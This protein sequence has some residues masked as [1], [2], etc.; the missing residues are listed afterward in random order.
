MRV[1]LY[2]YIVQYSLILLLSH[3]ESSILLLLLSTCTCWPVLQ[4]NS[5]TLLWDTLLWKA[6]VTCTPFPFFY[7]F[8]RLVWMDAWMLFWWMNESCGHLVSVWLTVII[9]YIHYYYIH[10][11]YSSDSSL[12]GLEHSYFH[13]II[14]YYIIIISSSFLCFALQKHWIFSKFSAFS[15]EKRWIQFSLFST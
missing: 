4:S 10:I 9:Q 6:E 3:S 7:L 15:T 5:S 12:L 13:S 8:K 11:I 2:F 14:I 1:F